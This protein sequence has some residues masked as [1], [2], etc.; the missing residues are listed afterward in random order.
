MEPCLTATP[1]IQAPHS[2][3]LY[4]SKQKLSQPQQHKILEVNFYGTTACTFQWWAVSRTQDPFSTLIV[5]QFMQLL[6][7]TK[8]CLFKFFQN[9]FFLFPFP[10]FE[11]R[12]GTPELEVKWKILWLILKTDYMEI[13]RYFIFLDQAFYGHRQGKFYCLFRWA[14]RFMISMFMVQCIYM[15]NSKVNNRRQHQSGEILL[16]HQGKWSLLAF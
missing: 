15:F 11:R 13:R 8:L 14:K 3:T 12:I 9:K 16:Q 7:L 5:I 1:L 10:A 2:A 4:W 6:Y